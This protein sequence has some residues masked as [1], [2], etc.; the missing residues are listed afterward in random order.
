MNQIF[1]EQ[2][3]NRSDMWARRVYQASSE[4]EAL[5]ARNYYRAPWGCQRFEDSLQ[6]ILVIASKCII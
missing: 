4:A 1:F 3:A 5:A 2:K 6:I